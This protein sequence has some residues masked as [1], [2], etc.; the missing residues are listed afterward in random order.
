MGFDFRWE[1][2]DADII[3]PGQD[4]YLK[5]KRTDVTVEPSTGFFE[6]N[7]IREFIATI[8]FA[9]ADVGHYRGILR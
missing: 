7:T 2:R 8:S 4:K 5:L 6:P 3:P 1:M 9:D